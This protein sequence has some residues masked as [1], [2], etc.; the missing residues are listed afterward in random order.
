[1]TTLILYTTA[2]CHL[3]EL[4]DAMLQTLARQY[5]LTIIPTEI[6]DDDQLVEHY[7]VRI[8]VVKF[9][10]NTDIGWPF[11]QHDIEIKLTQQ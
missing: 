5:Q 8:P 10:D 1:M 4:A 3:C 2:G 6:G 11:D 9:P 7:G